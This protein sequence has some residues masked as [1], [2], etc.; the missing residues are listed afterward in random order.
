MILIYFILLFIVY[1][2]SKS[3]VTFFILLQVVSLLGIVFIGQDF[4]IDTFFKFFNLLLTIVVLTLVIVPWQGF[5]NI[6]EITF[7]N[8][9]KLKKLTKFL[10]IISIFPFITFIVTSTFVFLFVDD[11][12]KFKYAEG[13]SDEFYYSLPFDVRAIILSAYLYGFSYFLIPLHFYY[14]AKKNYKLSFW[15]F[16]LSL[17]IILFGLT[18]FSRSA[19]VHYALI[20]ISFLIILYGTLESRIKKIIKKT[21][22]VSFVFILLYFVNVSLKRFTEDNLYADTIPANSFIQD[23]VLYSYF[24]YLS[25]WYYNNMYVLNTY[26]FKNFNGQL[27]LQP[28]LTLLGQYGI[29]SYDPAY[30]YSLRQQLW[31]LHWYS[32]NGFVAYSI[33]DM[34]YILTILFCSIYAFI[35]VRLKPK[36]NQMPL[37]NLFLIVLLVQIPILAIFYSA[38]GGIVIPLLLSIP[39]L[40]YL[41]ISIKKTV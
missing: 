34:G 16:L 9:A 19:F 14:L 8:E 6:K 24:D 35:V 33:Y 40:L 10:L 29:I 17:N 36:N 15:C 1:L 30:Y 26:E 18:Y 20:Y 4:P 27:S 2:K 38:V 11:I 5:K 7:A 12:N 41:K 32:F 23:P 31:P 37:L 13:V 3:V 25:Q 22:V 28:L 39:I 21:M